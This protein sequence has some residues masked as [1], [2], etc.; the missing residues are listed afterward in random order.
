MTMTVIRLHNVEGFTCKSGED[1]NGNLWT[2]F[3]VD[4]L[5]EQEDGECCICSA[6][7]SA[8]W[9]CMDGGEE[10]CGDHVELD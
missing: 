6:I 9:L 4:Y 5:A 1:E 7:I 8:G 10:V 2:Q 3:E